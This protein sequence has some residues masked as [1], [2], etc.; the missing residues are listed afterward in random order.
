MSLKVCEI[1]FS[2]QGESTF[3]GRPCTFVRLS[4][5]NL[6]CIWCD[7]LYAKEDGT[8]MDIPSIMK[9][10]ASFHC[11]LIEITG[12][13]PLI[14]NS[15]PELITRFLNAGFEVLL[16]TNGSR[17]IETI[18]PRCIKII[19]IKGPSS[20]EADSFLWENLQ[21]V[22]SEDEI[23]FVI[24]SR[25]DY[26]FAKNVIQNRL[27]RIIHAGKIHLSPVLNQTRP[28]QLAAWMIEDGLNARLSLQTHKIIWDPD[29]RGV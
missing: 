7:T 10:A 28:D 3:T 13:E 6:N 8:L 1:F 27:P 23:K 19:D 12:G 29:K 17:S 21:F 18:H 5:C 26:D 25:T 22:T 16:E 14:Q 20:G 9:K 15:T 4:G 2:L 11:R 24:G